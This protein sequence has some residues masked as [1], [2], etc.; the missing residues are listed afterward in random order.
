M[1]FL[2]LALDREIYQP[3]SR[4]QVALACASRVKSVRCRFVPKV[5]FVNEL[6]EVEVPA[7]TTL[8]QAA[9]QAGVSV[10]RGFWSRLN[11]R[12]LGFCGSCKTWVSPSTPQA[13]SAPGLRERARYTIRGTLRLGCLARV[14]GDVDVRTKPGGPA[15]QRTLEAY[16]VFAPAGAAVPPPPRP[17]DEPKGA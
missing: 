3:A 11:C 12:G 10:H 5:H 2:L 17:K 15:P 7:G 8:L 14:L 9:E 13:L 1:A 4:G 6:V 16:D